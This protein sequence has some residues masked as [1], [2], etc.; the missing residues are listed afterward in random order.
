MV[1]GISSLGVVF[2]LVLT[3][4]NNLEVGLP[5]IIT[6]LTLLFTFLKYFK[7]KTRKD[8]LY[9]PTPNNTPHSS[10]ERFDV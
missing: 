4:K 8:P 3:D 1:A 9:F 2:A 10:P 6:I 7:P 5:Y